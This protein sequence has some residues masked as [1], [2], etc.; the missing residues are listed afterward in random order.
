LLRLC[1]I[2]VRQCL[3]QNCLYAN[4]CR[5]RPKLPL[6]TSQ[7][8]FGLLPLYCALL[9]ICTSSLASGGLGSEEVHKPRKSRGSN[10][11]KSRY[12]E[13]HPSHRHGKKL[14]E[15]SGSIAS[16]AASV[17]SRMIAHSV[18][19]CMARWLMREHYLRLDRTQCSDQGHRYSLSL[20][21]R[22][23]ANFLATPSFQRVEKEKVPTEI[24]TESLNPEDRLKRRDGV[25][26]TPRATLSVALAKVL[27]VFLSKT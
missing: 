15:G 12:K 6:H 17:G 24:G 22:R 5:I 25:E 18:R 16:R 2:L 9:V 11:P 3:E 13:D 26:I 21:T 4:R 7:R 27:R 8:C 14:T 1:E 23:Q 10:P 20:S 19:A